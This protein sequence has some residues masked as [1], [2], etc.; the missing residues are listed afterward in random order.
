MWTARECQGNFDW[1][2]QKQVLRSCVRPVSCCLKATGLDE[3]RVSEAN[4]WNAIVNRLCPHGFNRSAVTRS[5][6]L[7]LVIISY[8]TSA[9]RLR[10]RQNRRRSFLR[11]AATSTQQPPEI[12]VSQMLRHRWRR[13]PLPDKPRLFSR[14]PRRHAPFY[15]QAQ[16]WPHAPVCA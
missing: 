5:C 10:F 3:V 15:W 4:Q 12:L 2:R 1:I 11:H 13:W 14:P 7:F 9:A 6:L 16:P 8:G